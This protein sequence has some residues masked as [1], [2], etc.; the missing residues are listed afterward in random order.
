MLKKKGFSISH[1]QIHKLLV[2]NGL[3]KPNLKKQKPRKWVRY[4]LPYQND[5]WHT[6]WS[7]DNFTGNQICVYTDDRTRLITSSGIF[8]R[9]TTKNSITLLKSSMACFG[10]PKCI[11]TDH[12][13]QYY[14]N[15]AGPDDHNT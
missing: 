3:V 5:M 8:K 14:A 11:K 6:D 1:R 13:S 10:K 9:A 4:E 12:G 2:R 7:Y 15:K